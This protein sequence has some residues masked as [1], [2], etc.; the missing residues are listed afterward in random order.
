MWI[1]KYPLTYSIRDMFTR[2]EYAKRHVKLLLDLP[3][4]LS[5]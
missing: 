3:K 4:K 2:P 1:C 5:Q